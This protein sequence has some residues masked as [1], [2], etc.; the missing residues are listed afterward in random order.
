MND[1]GME[2][3]VSKFPVGKELQTAA[4]EPSQVASLPVTVIVIVSAISEHQRGKPTITE[5]A[6]VELRRTILRE[7]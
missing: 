7:Q 6:V 5:R 4:I 3:G 1:L 2:G